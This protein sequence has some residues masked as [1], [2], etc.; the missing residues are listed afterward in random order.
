[1]EA[2]RVGPRVS[3]QASNGLC[4][5]GVGSPVRP[6]ARPPDRWQNRSLRKRTNQKQM[7]VASSAK[8]RDN[9]CTSVCYDLL[10]V[11]D[12]NINPRTKTIQFSEVVRHK[13]RSKN[14]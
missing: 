10:I 5:G 1:M 8:D 9:T 7:H 2:R 6:F 11:S 14:T 4:S 12:V 3:S 13:R